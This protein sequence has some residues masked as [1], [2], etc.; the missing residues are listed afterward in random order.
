ME[1]LVSELNPALTVPSVG[2]AVNWDF[3]E[4]NCNKLVFICSFYDQHHLQIF[5][6]AKNKFVTEQPITNQID[7]GM[8]KCCYL[9]K[10]GSY[11]ILNQAK[12]FVYFVQP[13]ALGRKIWKIF[14]T[15]NSH[16]LSFDYFIVDHVRQIIYFFQKNKVTIKLS[17]E[18]LFLGLSAYHGENVLCISQNVDAKLSEME[19]PS[20]FFVNNFFENQIAYSYFDQSKNTFFYKECSIESSF[21]CSNQ[22]VDAK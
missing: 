11:L 15:T 7:A 8:I 10:T 14:L 21:A 13:R 4:T 3:F 2:E 12:P 16:S 5:D 20:Y 6:V 1:G 9:P 17:I 18:K 22:Q 19:N